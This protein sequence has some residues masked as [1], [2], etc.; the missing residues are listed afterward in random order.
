MKKLSVLSLQS[1]NLSGALPA[2][3]GELGELRRLDLSFNR[4][5][6]S[7]PTRLADAPMLNVLDVRNNTLSGSVP[8]G[9]IRGYVLCHGFSFIYSMVA[10]A[11]I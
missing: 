7:I 5:F 1:N 10:D 9:I 8:L 6:G 11:K 3:L 2:S 4:L